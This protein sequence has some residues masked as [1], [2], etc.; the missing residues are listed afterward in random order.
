MAD[1]T[2]VKSRKGFFISP[3]GEAM[4]PERRRSDVVLA[5]ILKPALVPKYV[6]EIDRADRM[7]DPGEITPAIV[8]AIV[9]A[10]LIIADLSDANPNVYYELAI[11]HAFAKPVIHIIEEGH[12]PRFDVKDVRA[13]PYAIDIDKALLAQASLG[14][15]ARIATERGNQ[16]T[17]VSRAAEL[18]ASAASE[19]PVERQLAELRELV[20]DLGSDRVDARS[21]GGILRDGPRGELLDSRS[22]LERNHSINVELRR[23]RDALELADRDSVAR[24]VTEFAQRFGPYLDGVLGDSIGGTYLLHMRDEPDVADNFDRIQLANAAEA[25]LAQFLRLVEGPAWRAVPLLPSVR[26]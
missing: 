22:H 4:S 18:R 8:N 25:A 5:H 14:D 12:R 2:P 15:A 7:A 11:A 9:D 6:D 1:E 24:W 19:N 26:S 16:P 21:L 13:F 20:L 3:I 17:L 23:T 10:D